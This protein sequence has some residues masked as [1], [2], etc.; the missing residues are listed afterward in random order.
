MEKVIVVNGGVGYSKKTRIRVENPGIN[1]NLYAT[2]RTGMS[3]SS[4]NFL[5]SIGPD[6]GLLATNISEESLQDV[7]IMAPR[8]LRQL[9]NLIESSDN[10]VGSEKIFSKVD[11]E[12][13][14]GLAHK[15]RSLSNHWLKERME[16]P[17]LVL[18]VSVTETDLV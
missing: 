18:M 17:I 14:S 3:I 15:L 16:N 12:V 11:L 9:L 13:F 2:F 5:T 8:K 7:D 10:G 6:D 1:A 4:T